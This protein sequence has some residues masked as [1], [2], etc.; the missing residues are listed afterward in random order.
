MFTIPLLFF[1]SHLVAVRGAWIQESGIERP[2]ASFSSTV[3]PTAE[4]S[5]LVG[6]DEGAKCSAS[7][8]F[9][10]KD[11]L[12]FSVSLNILANKGLGLPV[13][14]RPALKAEFETLSDECLECF[15]ANIY[16][17][18][19]NCAL[20]CAGGKSLSPGCLSCVEEAC[21]PAFRTCL[22]VTL[23]S[24]MP[25]VPTEADMPGTTQAPQKIR[26]RKVKEPAH[27]GTPSGAN[28][29]GEL[30]VAT[31]EVAGHTTPHHPSLVEPL[32]GGF[33]TLGFR[34]EI[35][36]GLSCIMALLAF[37]VNKLAK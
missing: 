11:N 16:C 22:G 5:A 31:A 12:P 21:I 19:L 26:T 2:E 32:R 27:H 9:T 6:S 10:W 17:G 1:F 35:I 13:F 15:V 23:D 4:V 20:Y 34:T 18:A 29:D 28:S 3:V 25:P 33:T 30:S 14:V 8:R 24:E 36:V 7:E 37:V